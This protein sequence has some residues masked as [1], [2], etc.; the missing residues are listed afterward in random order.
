MYKIP[1][2]QLTEKLSENASY[3]VYRGVRSQ[4][5]FPVLLRVLN[6]PHP[7]AQA[8]AFLW[9]EYEILRGL[10]F[11]GVEKI[12]ALENHDQRW[13][14]VVEDFGGMPLDRQE[15]AGRMEPEEFLN[16]ALQ[17]VET[18]AHIHAHQI[19]H[20]NI[21]PPNIFY[22]PST[23]QTRLA[24]FGGASWISKEKVLLQSPYKLVEFLPY[25][26]PEMT[27]RMNRSVD[28]RADYYSL[29]ATLYELLTGTPPF[30]GETP[31]ELVYAH[32]AVLPVP[33]ASRVEPWKAS[34]PA[35]QIISAILLKLLAKNPEGR[36]QT[37]GALRTDLRQALS[38]LQE[39]ASADLLSS[40]FITG[41]DDRPD[42]LN[43]PQL[44]VGR[45]QETEALL[46][47]FLRTISGPAELVLVSGEAGVGKTTLVNQLVRPVTE[48][49]GLFLYAKFDQ[50]RQQEAYHAFTQVLDEFCRLVLSE[51]MPSFSD[52]RE[53]LQAAV[54]PHGQL[55]IELCPQLE[56]VIGLQPPVEPIDETLTRLRFY[57]VVIRFLQAVCRPEHP[58][59]IFLDDMQWINLDS[60]LLWQ[61]ILSASSLQNLLVVGAYREDEVLS[62]KLINRLVQD[63]TSPQRRVTQLR[64]ENL[65]C[66]MIG[67]IM[68]AALASDPAE[69][70]DLVDLVCRRTGGNPYF[71]K[72][73]LKSLYQDRLLSFDQIEQKWRWDR[74]EIEKSRIVGLGSKYGDTGYGVV[75]LFVN[76][77]LNLREQTQKTLQYAALI[78]RRFDTETLLT[79]L[80]EDKADVLS[81]S[82]REG[83]HAGLI[84]PLGE[85]YRL[86]FAA[87]EQP[88]ENSFSRG[89]EPAGGERLPNLVDLLDEGVLFEFQHDRVQQAAVAMLDKSQFESLSLQIGWLLLEKAERGGEEALLEEIFEIVDYLNSGSGLIIDLMESIQLARLNL[90]ASRKAR[91]IAAFK[92][93]SSYL[94]AGMQ[95]LPEESWQS[96]YELTLEI[97]TAGADVALLNGDLAHAE[98]LALSAEAHARTLLEKV[99]IIKT[100][101]E[102]YTL[103]N[104]L[105][106]V[107]ELGV[108]AIKMFGFDPEVSEPPAFR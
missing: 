48:K 85:G 50:V 27:G 60:T 33:P 20:K 64:L 4:D 51:P 19:I 30:L 23:R 84:Y 89:G 57:Q 6:Q 40:A 44:V 55:L 47:A 70:S 43:I 37:H 100:R 1:G 67:Q 91:D 107:V 80:G 77:I 13:M 75:D 105:D 35:F 38:V 106:Q 88:L 63:E 26:S 15:I 66:S 9:Q 93:A 54:T 102:V 18:L 39:P 83:I 68:A 98:A 17:M 8:L 101:M 45:E 58:V 3:Q 72:E 11:P 90:M 16:L 7:T 49:M 2:Y 99:V 65:D 31:L 86:L 82:L 59:V 96:Q 87:L 92:A 41:Q 73:L 69:V 34:A 62:D 10:D 76:R 36:Y 95:L 28:Y 56:K 71:S 104:R 46:Q 97:F 74:K 24:N 12:Y 53:R 81:Y 103:L 5:G 25:I 42:Q 22:N 94:S 108:A 52:W 29:G 14:L 61:S 78:G 79:L 32:L 21:S